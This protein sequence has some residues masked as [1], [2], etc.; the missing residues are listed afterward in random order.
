[1]F[2]AWATATLFS[3]L[4]STVWA[5]L[6]GSDPLEATW[7]AG[8]MLM[9]MG[10]GPRLLFASAALVHLTVSLL[11]AL[12]FWALLPQRHVVLWSV[13]G[14]AVVAIVDLRLIAPLM[15]QSI[16]ALEFWPQFADHL[17]WGTCLGIVL[18]LHPL[19]RR[20]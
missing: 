11:W 17:M 9:P 18:H 6:T 4:P 15:F 20:S 14:S 10:A 19:A 5:L 3:G 1:M 13:V 2:Y 7:A 12:I 16:V 8:A